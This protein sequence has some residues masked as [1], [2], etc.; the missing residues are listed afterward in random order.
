MGPQKSGAMTSSP[1]R[2]LLYPTLPEYDVFKTR[3]DKAVETAE[4]PAEAD[5]DEADSP[6]KTADS[7]VPM[8]TRANWTG[9]VPAD[10]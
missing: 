5:A 10:D 7:N 1:S 4:S 2:G 6:A 9:T 3:T 8:R